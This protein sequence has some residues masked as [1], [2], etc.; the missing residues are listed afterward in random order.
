[1][2][3]LSWGEALSLAED[4]G[5]AI[6]NAIKGAGEFYCDMIR[7]Y[8]NWSLSNPL[9]LDPI[10]RA[11]NDK[12][13]GPSYPPLPPPL[14]PITGGGCRCIRYRVSWEGKQNLVPFSG[15]ADV[16]GPV[17]QLIIEPVEGD[18]LR[19]IFY[20]QNEECTGWTLTGILQAGPPSSWRDGRNEA[21][22]TSI[23]RLDGLPDECRPNI[24]TYPP[25]IPPPEVTQRNVNINFGPSIGVN[26]PILI[27][28]PDIDIDVNNEVNIDFQP[29]FELPDINLDIKFD[30][31]GVT[32]NPTSGGDKPPY[33]PPPD[34]RTDPPKL[35]ATDLDKKLK[36][37]KDDLKK[38]KEDLADLE[39]CACPDQGTPRVTQYTTNNALEVSVPQRVVSCT[40]ELTQI[41]T[42]ARGQWGGGA[43]DVTFSGW[44]W[45]KYEDGGLSERQPIDSSLKAFIP[46]RPNPVGFAYTLQAGFSGILRVH[47]REVAG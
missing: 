43:P 2:P 47:W 44:G 28:R 32:I 23:V 15:F 11:I 25:V 3:E 7:E 46:P 31:G 40:I 19:A 37:I 36:P 33:L 30:I 21:R 1:M 9:G 45:F 4:A 29:H 12:L 24:P 35:P 14:P 8:P 42:N 6:G 38:V 26:V 41:P 39:K 22:I 10:S 17:G 13:C 18:A 27:V 34:P 20:H 16:L 5:S